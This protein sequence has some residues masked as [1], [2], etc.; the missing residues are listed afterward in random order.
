MI[1]ILRKVGIPSPE[2]IVDSSP[3][4]LSGGMRQRAMIAMALSCNPRILVADEPATALDV[5]LQA[6]VLGLMRQMIT[7]FHTSV[8][9]ITHD[10]GVVAEIADRVVVMYL[11]RV[12]ESAPVDELFY[13]P[14]HPYT[15][16]LIR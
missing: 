8:I 2:E 16:A 1:A 15:Q 4:N 14:R 11:G 7:D 5:T 13:A 9:F 10:L 12:V 6:Q 3:H